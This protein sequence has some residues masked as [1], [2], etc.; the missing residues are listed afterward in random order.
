V[1][2]VFGRF[3]RQFAF[4]FNR[5]KYDAY[6]VKVDP[7]QEDK[8]TEIKLFSFQR[9][10]MRAFHV[11]WW[12]FFMA[13]F[14]WFAISPLLPEIRKTLKLT[15]KK[16]W[17][18]SVVGVGGTF[19]V[20]FLL[21]PLNDKYG[22][23]WLMS[24]VLCLGAIP[25]GLI[26]LVN[27]F[28]GLVVIRLFI[29]F[30]G[31]SFVMCQYWMSKMFAK[32]IVG[33]ANAVAG[34]WGNLGG[35]VTLLVMG[36][37]LFPAFKSIYDGDA[38]KAW[39]TVCVVPAV[40]TFATGLIGYYISDDAPKGNFHE[41]KAH[42]TMPEVS[43]TASLRSGAVNF[44]TWILFLHY[45]V[46]FGVELTMHSGVALYFVEEFGLTTE[47]AAAIGSIFGWLN[48][49]SRG[50][51]GYVSDR[52]NAA[53]G[54]RGRLYTQMFTILA[55]GACILVFAKTQSLAWSIFVMV[56]FSIFC[57]GGCGT[58]YGI[59][60]YVDPPATGAISGIVGA[61]GNA[62]AVCFGCIFAFKGYR[63]AF[64]VMGWAVMVSAFSTF[65]IVIKGYKCL[66]WGEDSV[67]AQAVG[68]ITVPEE[69]K[70]EESDSS[71][72]EI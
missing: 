28:Q 3:C 33:T 20:R 67:P 14:I 36:S 64:T 39:R 1:S 18:S 5:K 34:G 31:G 46:T 26:G 25:V 44:N 55:E 60:P 53:I 9:P 62:G 49:F 7:N 57:Q 72:I 40:V 32:E 68:T 10:H 4:V 69:K 13:F 29:G 23:R 22:A 54:M 66:I 50:L 48:I 61:G 59:V 12:S 51:G 11:C 63:L 41:M 52:T 35:G 17:I 47:R 6:N 43:A 45:A 16:I 37:I 2:L 70:L 30:V 15:K 56:W 8:A 65:F 21:G 19:F 58:T 27:S 38:E 71:D 24:A 42:G